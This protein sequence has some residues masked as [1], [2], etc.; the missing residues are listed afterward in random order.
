MNR[1]VNIKNVKDYALV[2]INRYHLNTLSIQAFFSQNKNTIIKILLPFLIIIAGY[3]SC[4]RSQNAIKDD[5]DDIFNI[6]DDIRSFFADKPD[7]WG[8]DTDFVIKNKIISPA[9]IKQN[10]LLLRH[11]TEIK[12]GNGKDAETVMPSSQSF[13]V[14]MLNLTR[15]QCISYAEAV[16]TDAQL[17]KLDKIDII[18]QNA[19]YSFEWGGDKKLPIAINAAHDICLDGFNTLIWTLK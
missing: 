14:V 3:F 11:G 15:K 7:Y 9:F 1:F 19:I 2:L 5:L 13:D 6:S 8:L 4:S 16:L 10:R 18:N 17:L 12:I